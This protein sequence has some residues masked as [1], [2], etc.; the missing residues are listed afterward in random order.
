MNI[1]KTGEFGLIDII[2]K[3]IR[4]RDKNIKVGIGDDCAVI[5]IGNKLAVLT[6]DTLVE[7]DH[8]SLE[9][10][11]PEQ[12]GKKAI[13]INVSDIT[14]IGGIPKYALVSMAL[15]RDLDTK[16]FDKIYSGIV[17]A[18]KKYNIEI[19]GG[20]LTNAKQVMINID[21]VGFVK[22]ENLCLRSQAK[23]GDLILVT[24]DLGGS[25]AGLNLFLKK[26]KGFEKI[27]RKHLE[28]EAK[29]HKVKKFLKYINAMEDV[30]DGLASE[31]KHIC[32][33]SNVGAVIYAANIPIKDE[34][35][36]AA[37]IVSKKAL[38]YALFGGEDFELVFTVSEKNLK[39]VR[40]FLIGE[41][42]KKKGVYLYDRSKE[43]PIFDRGYDHFMK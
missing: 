24:G 1:T 33:E 7:G 35:R 23:P 42:R 3:K 21:M 15:R 13:E 31:I 2:K 39:K 36:K 41:I 11:K 32:K 28:P 19:V 34:T 37:K 17:K 18:A 27:K 29:P 16:V 14:S 6:T 22:K 38:N 4:N 43:K 20:N 40:G 8:F 9:Y 12:I 25:A 5:R 26:I 30:S 10:F